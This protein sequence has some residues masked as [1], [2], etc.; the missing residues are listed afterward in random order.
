MGRRPPSPHCT[1]GMEKITLIGYGNPLCGD[2]GVGWAVA[3]AIERSMLPIDTAV[4]HQLTPEW[5]E[6]ISQS[7]LVI[8]VDAAIEGVPGEVRML[9]LGP[10]AAHGGSHETTAEGVLSMAACL[11]G[12]CPPAYM[13]AITGESFELS[14]SLSP[15]IAAAVP[16][17]VQLIVQLV[18][19]FRALAPAAHLN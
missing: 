14:E 13:V 8:F 4:I 17:A 1:I 9:P 18:I 12:Y 6:P 3:E 2:D 5:A 19:E 10:A 15:R 7:N 16:I 11:Y